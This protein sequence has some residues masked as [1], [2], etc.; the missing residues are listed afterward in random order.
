VLSSLSSADI[1]ADITVSSDGMCCVV[2]V[3]WWGNA[4]NVFCRWVEWQD[5]RFLPKQVQR[6]RWR[7]LRSS[8]TVWGTQGM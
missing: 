2:V 4:V 6:Q 8:H 1:S 3:G 5:E 7:T